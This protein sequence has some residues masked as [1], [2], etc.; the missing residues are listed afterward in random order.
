MLGGPLSQ[1]SSN[2]DTHMSTKFFRSKIALTF[3]VAF[4]GGVL[5]AS[6]MDLTRYSWAQPAKGA[7]Q[8]GARGPNSPDAVGSFANVAERVT[9]TVVAIRTVQVAKVQ[10]VPRSGRAVPPGMEDFFQQFG[11]GQ[12][13]ERQG[14][15]SGFILT[16]DGYII[17]NN[18]VV[19]DADRVT[20]TL[21]DQ[22]SFNAKVVGRDS[23]TDVAVVKI[24]AKNLPTLPVGDDNQARI[25]DWVLAVG[26]PLG[27]DFTVTAGIISAKSRG[28]T[29][30]GPSR[31]GM[32]ISDF[33]QTDAAINPGNSGGPL[34]NL[35]GEAIGLNSMIAS[36]TG[37]FSGYGFAIP[38]T[39]VKQVADQ[40]IKDG[41]VRLPVLGI[42]VGQV[43]ADDAGI[44]GLTGNNGVLVQGFNPADSGPAK[45]AGIM[46]GD[47]VIAIGGEPV[48]RVSA[49]QRVVRSH[50]VG[51]TVQVDVMRYG[52]K[53][54]FKVKLAEGNTPVRVASASPATPEPV[55]AP[56]PKLVGKLGIAVEAVPAEI[57]QGLKLPA[58]VGVKV[59]EVSSNSPAK[60]KLSAS[61]VQ[62]DIITDI[63]YPGPRRQVKTPAELQ[64]VIAGLKDGEYI[65]LMVTSL[66]LQQRSRQDRVVNIRAN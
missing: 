29:D 1:S 38:I 43:G 37:Y 27:L 58:G 62:V 23:T 49:L 52:T 55:A 32:T 18:H 24:D 56:G 61:P 35:K 39:L 48:T 42:S 6:G 60:D 14:E 59:S 13:P 65:S 17:T 36:E 34:I 22:R 54:Q 16:N 63:L 4:A 3:A 20:V 19:A 64:S 21:A 26:N 7:G 11:N 28:N 5:F 50:A 41:R 33:I 31:G 46:V 51:E 57:A 53:K 45:D 8:P 10:R 15:G 2:G 40:L 47:V 44:N 25:G 12:Q 9:P 66:D 30:L